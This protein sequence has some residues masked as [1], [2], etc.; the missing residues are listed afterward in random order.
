M[1]NNWK[2]GNVLFN[3]ALN[4]FYEALEHTQIT[5]DKLKVLI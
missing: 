2:E 5:I 4:T 1:K 3:N